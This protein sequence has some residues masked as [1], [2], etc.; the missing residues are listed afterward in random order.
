[1]ILKTEHPHPSSDHWSSLWPSNKLKKKTPAGIFFCP[2]LK[3]A[4][5]GEQTNFKVFEDLGKY[6]I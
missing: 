1:M 3:K 4:D 6:Y 2:N 5:F